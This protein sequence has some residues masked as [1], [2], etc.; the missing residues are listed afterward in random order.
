VKAANQESNKTPTWKQ[1][2]ESP[3]FKESSW[4]TRQAVRAK[5]YDRH[6]RPKAPE[7]AERKLRDDFFNATANDVFRNGGDE[8]GSE[9]TEE[10]GGLSVPDASYSGG[11]DQGQKIEDKQ[12]QK[13]RIN[14]NLNE[15][16][17]GLMEDR[18]GG[19]QPAIDPE[20]S[21]SVG[22]VAKQREELAESREKTEGAHPTIRRRS[23]D[24]LQNELSESE[25]SLS[26]TMEEA[27]QQ[28]PETL[29]L[30][31]PV[32]DDD[33][34]ATK[35]RK[36][37]EDGLRNLGLDGLLPGNEEDEQ[38]PSSKVAPGLRRRGLGDMVEPQEPDEEPDVLTDFGNLLSM[39]ADRA[40][41]NTREA[42]RNVFGE[43]VVDSIDQADEW[44]NGKESEELLSDRIER[45]ERE[46]TPETRE[47]RQKAW[48][49]SEQGKPG[50]AWS[51]WRSYFSGVTES[52]PE[53][54]ISMAPSMALSKGVYAWNLA[55]GIDPKKAA[56]RAATTA[57]LAGG[58]AEGLMGGGGS[59][60]E[61]RE[62]IK[63]M[64]EEQLADSEAMKS[65]MSE[66]DM[67]FEE[68]RNKLAEDASSQAFVLSGMATG[69]FGG[70]GDRALSRVLTGGPN[71]R[72]GSMLR[73]TVG[74]GVFEEMPQEAGQQVSENIVMGKAD[75]D[76]EPTDNVANAAMGGLAI[77]GAMGAGMG[78]AAGGQRGQRGQEGQQEPEVRPQ[79]IDQ[80]PQ[81]GQEADNLLEE[82]PGA[83][84]DTS[85]TRSGQDRQASQENQT[86]EQQDQAPT[87]PG[88]LIRQPRQ[89]LGPDQRKQRDGL[90]DGDALKSLRKRASDQGLDEEVKR[91]DSAAGQAQQAFEEETLARAN[92]DNEGLN[93]VRQKLETI[94]DTYNQV[95]D[96]VNQSESQAPSDL[97]E[98]GQEAPQR[99]QN[100]PR[101]RVGQDQKPRV[102]VGPDGQAQG[103]RE[104]EQSQTPTSAPTQVTRDM[105]TQLGDLGYPD[106]EIRRMT[107]EQAMEAIESGDQSTRA[108][109]E[110]AGQQTN[111]SPTPA[112]A[113]AGNY[114]KGRANVQGMEV[115][116]EN[117]K[118][119][120]RRGTDPDGN[121]WASTL[122]HDYGDIKGTRG[123]DGD[124]VDVFVG[125]QPDTGKT[126][127]IDQL[128]E[129][130]NFDEHK[131][132]VGFPS[133]EAARRGYLANY[134]EGWNGLGQI[135]ESTTDEVRSWSRDGDT[136]KPFGKIPTRNQRSNRKPRNQGA[137]DKSRQRGRS[138]ATTQD[139]NKRKAR[140][141]EQLKSALNN[142]EPGDT[143]T[144]NNRTGYARGNTPYQVL[145]Y[146]DSG[147]VWLENLQSGGRTSLKRHE[148]QAVEVTTERNPDQ[149]RDEAAADEGQAGQDTRYRAT[150]KT[151]AQREVE[152]VV[153]RA[154]DA[155]IPVKAVANENGLPAPLRKA[156][157]RDGVQ[158]MVKGVQDNGTIWVVSANANGTSDTASTIL[159]EAFHLGVRRRLGSDL[160]PA[161]GGIYRDMP[162]Q[163]KDRIREL[164]A[165]Q[166]EGLS[167]QGANRLVAEE[168]A[169]HLAQ[170]DPSST[171]LD[172]MVSAI[173]RWL[174]R[175][176][177]PRVAKEWGRKE[178]V[179]LIA[180]SQ[181]ALA[182]RE[183][184][185]DTVRYRIREG[186]KGLP[187]RVKNAPTVSVRFPKAMKKTFDPQANYGQLDIKT[188]GKAQL[189]ERQAELI[190]NYPNFRPTAGANTPQKKLARLRSHVESNLLW[191]FDMVPSDVRDQVK[192]WYEGANRVS[193]TWAERYGLSNKQTAGVIA[194]LSPQKDWF[195]NASLAERLLDTWTEQQNTA[196]SPAMTDTLN[197]VYG[198][199]SY[200]SL[201]QT[202]EG[203]RLSEIEDAMSQ[204]AW[205]RVFDE[206]FNDRAYRN[207]NPDGSLGDFATTDR[208]ENAKV[209]WG[210]N[211]EIK[212]AVDLLRDGS[213][214]NL[215]AQ[216]GGQHKVRN[217]YNNIV[218]PNSQRGFV[219]IDT[220]AVAAG[221]LQPLAGGS[222]EVLHNFGGNVTGETG[223]G[224][225]SAYGISGTYA[226]YAEAYR[227][228]AAKRDVL[229][230]EMQSITWEMIR[231]LFRPG[232]KAQ[233]ANTAK[234][235]DVWTDFKN[236]RATLEQ[237]RRQIWD[238]AGG[239]D[240]N[241]WGGSD[242]TANDPA[243]TATYQR[244]V[245][246]AG[247]SGSG[248]SGSAPRGRRGSNAARALPGRPGSRDG[249]RRELSERDRQRR[250]FAAQRPGRDGHETARS[251]TRRSPGNDRGLRGVVAS[252][253]PKPA[254]RN[255]LRDTRL[256]E[257]ELQEL[258]TSPES[259]RRFTD[260]INESKKQSKYGAAVYV[261]P[262]NDYQNMRLFMTPD[263][264]SGLAIKEDGDIVSVFSD[265]GGKVHPMLVLAVEQGGTKLDGF[266]TVLPDIYAVNGFKEV[267]RDSWNEDYRPEGWDKELF[268]PFNGGEPDV[269][270]MVYDPS[271]NPFEGTDPR[272][273]LTGDTNDGGRRQSTGNRGG[274]APSRGTTPLEGTPTIRGATGPDPELNR[275][276]ER[277]AEQNG[278]D[279]QRQAEYVE[280]DVERAERIAQA[281]E[282]MEHAPQDP[283]VKE[284]YQDLVRQ[285]R[286]Q[287]D[288]L[289]N[290]GYEFYFFDG[291][292]DPYDGNPW[293][294]MRDLR[295]NKRMAVFTTE[296]GFGTDEDFDPT[297]NPLLED[298]GIKWAFGSPDGP[299]RRV[300]AN[301]LFRA[302]HDA[303]GH[304]LEG[305]GFRARGEENAWQAHVR[306][307][308]GPAIG[309]LTSETRG[310]NSWLNFGP[311]G[312]H[313]RTAGILDTVFADQK[314]GLMPEWA[315]TEGRADT[316][317]RYS[318]DND[319]GQASEDSSVN[320]E[321][322][323]GGAYSDNDSTRFG[324]PDES[325]TDTFLRKIADKML[326]IKRLE[327][328][329]QET[330]G[331]VNE[332]NDA[333]LAEELFHGKTERDL[334]NL[335]E[336]YVKRLA[337]GLAETDIEQAALD[338]YLYARHA[339]ERNQVIAE[340][341]PGDSRYQDG[342]SGMTNA[343]ASEIIEMVENSGKQE[344]FDR[345]AN[346]VYEMLRLRREAI[347]E[348]GLETDGTVDAWEASYEAY[349]PLK[350]WAR[351]EDAPGG[352]QGAR[353]QSTGRG[354]EISGS[355]A[356]TSLGRRSKAAS[357]STQAI[358]DTTQSLV[359][360]RKNEVGQSLLSLMND[361]PN[362]DVW[363]VFTR[364]RPDV[365]RQKV[366]RTDPDTGEKRIFV[367]LAPVAME[368]NDRYF[369]V[370][371]NGQTFYLKLHNERLLN[372]MRNVG[373]ESNNILVRGIGG[374]VRTMASLVTSYNPEFLIS[375]F[376]R[377]VQTAML[378]L[379]AEQTRE[380]GKIK[381]K[382]IL[383]Q[384]A[385]D[386]RPAMRAA[387][388]G[389][390]GKPSRSTGPGRIWD[391]YFQEFM[392]DGAKTGYFDMKD[393]DSQ[394]KAIQKM[395]RRSSGGSMA[396]MLKGRKATA[397]FV[398]NVN[399]A[400][401]NAVRL[402]AYVN[403]RKAGISRP[404]AA[405]LA[406]NMTVN[407]N[408]RGELG[409]L[410]NSAY[411]FF[412]A[413]VQGTA[414]FARAMVTI[415]PPQRGKSRINAWSR[416][417]L[418]Q[419]L[420]AGM[421]TGSFVLSM[422]NRMISD[423]D[424][425]GQLYWDKV[426][427]YIKERN[428]VLMTGDKDYVSVP[429]PYG[430][431]VFSVIGTHFEAVLSGEKDLVSAG[432]DF[433]LAALGSFSPVGFEGSDDAEN[434]LAKNISPTL[435]RSITQLA[436]N[437]DFSGQPIYR[438][439]FPFGTPSPDSSRSF[440]STPN[441]YKS[442]AEF[443]NKLTG[444]S[445]YVS[446]SV[447]IAPETFQH[448]TNFYG[449]G[450]YG[451]T[452]KTVD[453]IS[454][455]AQ[456]EKMER[457]RIPFVGKI[458]GSV[459][460][461][462]DMDTFYQRRDEVGQY[463]EQLDNLPADKAEAFYRNHQAKIDL[464][465][466]ATE[467]EQVLKDLRSERDA[468]EADEAISE[469][470]R[471]EAVERI[472]EAIESEVDYF[473]REYRREV[474]GR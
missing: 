313:N 307:F 382:H 435:L 193:R 115:A 26:E 30:K 137:G 404:K 121:E 243:G 457:W 292:T 470:E 242:R 446:G 228:A 288:A 285:T 177:G 211:N 65:L 325:L 259:A 44:M 447:D 344:D 19:D 464:F 218:A 240:F 41:L 221:L 185:G 355:E 160:D 389:L 451:F 69:A 449:G 51:D 319:A 136:T 62:Q 330:G 270:Y 15:A 427:S 402:S 89:D 135:T 255:L 276:A 374:V 186:E 118:G 251:F 216:L 8:S 274:R 378:N 25:A 353:R 109:I 351:D 72:L 222:R 31:T 106:G 159:H 428:L 23:Q 196:W 297:D 110:E 390:S 11:V 112:Q 175:A 132:M 95:A 445:E 340:R 322:P 94:G 453:A 40:A 241:R 443:L 424:E 324:L 114:R 465:D 184:G 379:S 398:E 174:R 129:Q 74:E 39:G 35:G 362:P 245:S 371:S 81:E 120:T 235:V 237:T 143:V 438:E 381:G 436:V 440:R 147:E 231:E 9:G 48:W 338:A 127:V 463:A 2:A 472:E 87:H 134:P 411:M 418:A 342:G 156:I 303:F 405:S 207:I 141:V 433:M 406:K 298:T 334:R 71:T 92:Q 248:E 395:M 272:Y 225:N 456:G 197:R 130:G 323:P 146:A 419:K 416:M 219:T 5:F 230:R 178:I 363:E 246:G 187:K 287:Y 144:F 188:L 388:R 358:V 450:A 36:T 328:K 224:S 3:E 223:P 201:R 123:A 73:T 459:S 117:P 350:G 305:A 24:R 409:T 430:Y 466:V 425:D 111:T 1:V 386:I 432:Q 364:D 206:T 312:E 191:L 217:F 397:D 347:R 91:L 387:Y 54:A 213:D 320:I 357:P 113:E 168:Y 396:A 331:Q 66:G 29:G 254:F 75:S 14:P 373:P 336:Q 10:S 86:I 279:L 335:E 249:Q 162:K 282:E 442:F 131:V 289:V 318:L 149:A 250:E 444:G 4:E 343:E 253:R 452:E 176:F 128:D 90:V 100:K 56:K 286:A 263:G 321:E 208:G 403:A 304:G 152:A 53:T 326:P 183:G 239:I 431:N 410:F 105:K 50:P 474:L 76:I 57:T 311:Y 104:P 209:A 96:R 55:K 212:K 7:G 232:Y 70:M 42:V 349:V 93:Q 180:D 108:R 258:D 37:L 78:A 214:A 414:N 38:D 157:E 233:A 166:L 309:A 413:S 138:A 299:R 471:N 163:W 417:N 139:R 80:Q 170:T 264:K 376:L 284:A 290:A 68:A 333:Y 220:H 360:R 234:I 441:A 155:G 393:I 27:G 61:V 262:P 125:D 165:G 383:R 448:L 204:G 294:A 98:S 20:L 64:S 421:V 267:G 46:L 97:Q 337:D 182:R 179:D 469:D 412:N 67:E 377:D 401:E 434:V 366:T 400:V 365:Q 200:A 454:R 12:D 332:E 265:G 256:P 244:D 293:N 426:P 142:A 133:K 99:R 280:V 283:R 32:A 18:E 273:S 6:V 173:R 17:V 150:Q 408:R 281:Y 341:N 84:P 205:I 310:Q 16:V 83:T 372:A 391:H 154:A 422:F 169:A 79:G 269:V 361:N 354:F 385:R 47:A 462:G 296:D 192:R 229:P 439:E 455:V 140:R 102:R 85:E 101:V 359:R 271:Y 59:S 291:E 346:I 257:V 190:E 82:T 370:K 77:G 473:N 199:D 460:D 236:G 88:D 103:L 13:P 181:A 261:Y 148:V 392:E 345:L 238:H 167:R 60:R 429:L 317:P 277:Y 295:V 278:I 172:R 437:E 43:E 45:N 467:V 458:L 316:D 368:M 198:K 153:R 194:A 415:D 21:Q 171:A 327:Q 145:E 315:W 202:I 375:N 380:D 49:D 339:P 151:L 247:L 275:V 161:L 268:A 302:V 461:Y 215:N 252:Y 367:E 369:K 28:Q 34:L 58:I 314:T 226:I 399:G 52:I 468:I 210:S 124:N 119:S 107:P 116:I 126:Y 306:L 300:L 420:A 33:D 407:F 301:D 164:Y 423:E 356:R 158:G 227:N 189:D 260:A 329:I 394:A 352:E 384:T 22:E 266:D 308:H 122:A 348:G 203:K 63:G 195:Q